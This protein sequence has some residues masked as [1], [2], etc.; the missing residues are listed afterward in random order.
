MRGLTLDATALSVRGVGR[1]L[2]GKLRR[3]RL[4]VVPDVVL[5]KG[6]RQAAETTDGENFR[7]QFSDSK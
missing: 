7:Y 4:E 1:D 2:Q 3:R 5:R 6:R